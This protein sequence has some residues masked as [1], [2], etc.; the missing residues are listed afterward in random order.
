MLVFRTPSVC[1]K[2]L[3]PK[4]HGH[5][6]VVQTIQLSMQSLL[7]F[8]ASFIVPQTNLAMFGR[9]EPTQD[10]PFFPFHTKA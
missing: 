2:Q 6:V 1:A 8:S 4:H 3:R 10:D 7:S 5:P 9:Q